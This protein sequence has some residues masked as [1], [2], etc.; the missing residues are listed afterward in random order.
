MNGFKSELVVTPL[1]NGRDWK[2]KS[3]LIYHVGCKR[4]PLS[5]KVPKNFITDFASLPQ[6]KSILSIWMPLLIIYNI[7]V[8]LVYI[9]I[10]S[11]SDKYVMPAV[12]HDY[13]YRKPMFSRRMADAIFIEAMEIR[14]INPIKRWV[15]YVFVRLL[16]R[17]SYR[18]KQ[19][20][21]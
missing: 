13:L 7:I 2:L 14:G 19:E 12:I 17:S 6:R 20:N 18:S 3:S 16:G 11:P 4:S 8:A 15:M 1:E 21:L 5:I 10:G 9:L